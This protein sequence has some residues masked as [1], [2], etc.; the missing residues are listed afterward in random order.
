MTTQQ[1]KIMRMISLGFSTEQIANEL[2]LSKNTIKTHRKD[3][4]EVLKARN[5]CHAVRLWLEQNHR[6][7][8]T[9]P[10]VVAHPGHGADMLDD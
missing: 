9:D 1:I 3:I 10:P 7:E 2:F 8:N 5:A 6:N 4:L